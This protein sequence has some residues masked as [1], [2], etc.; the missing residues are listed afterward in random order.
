[1][2]PL[3]G[4]QVPSATQDSIVRPRL[5]GHWKTCPGCTYLCRIFYATSLRL[6]SGYHPSGDDSDRSLVR[7]NDLGAGARA[8]AKLPQVPVDKDEAFPPAL[9]RLPLA[10]VFS[11]SPLRELPRAILGVAFREL[12]SPRQARAIRAP[13]ATD[14]SSSRSKR[15]PPVAFP[16]SNPSNIRGR[17]PG[18]HSLRREVPR[19]SK[20]LSVLEEAPGERILNARSLDGNWLRISRNSCHLGD[21]RSRLVVRHDGFDLCRCL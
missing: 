21:S 20:Y 12:C 15:L 9:G 11:A 19:R 16:P 2:L 5:W 17:L 10:R 7:R 4:T 1:M 14:D 3:P 18:E 13:L 6:N 8:G